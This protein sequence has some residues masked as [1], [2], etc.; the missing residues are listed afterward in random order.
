MHAG[1]SQPPDGGDGTVSLAQDRPP[2]VPWRAFVAGLVERFK[3]NTYRRALSGFSD[4]QLLAAGID[5][6]LAGR[7]PASAARPGPNLKGLR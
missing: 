1:F 2:I 5:L 6:S 4:R 7:R 3:R